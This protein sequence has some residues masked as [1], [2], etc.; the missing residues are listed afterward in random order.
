M[1]GE[2]VAHVA[3]EKKTYRA[4][5]QTEHVNGTTPKLKS[6]Q[7]RDAKTSSPGV[8]RSSLA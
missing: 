6:F 7:S 4:S 2:K 1:F 8:I 3:K 5:M